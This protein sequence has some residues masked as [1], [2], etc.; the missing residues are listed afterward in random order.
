MMN[1]RAARLSYIRS[2]DIRVYI[3]VFWSWVIYRQFVAFS[4]VVRVNLP[5]SDLQ[6]NLNKKRTKYSS[7]DRITTV[8]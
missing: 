6:V 4:V 5:S 3:Q 8:E 1:W 7:S 2:A